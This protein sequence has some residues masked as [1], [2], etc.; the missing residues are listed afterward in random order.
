M[1]VARKGLMLAVAILAAGCAH[2][3]PVD[4]PVPGGRDFLD[5]DVFIITA[6]PD[7]CA[8]AQREALRSESSVRV[9]CGRRVEG[10]SIS[11]DRALGP[12]FRAGPE[13]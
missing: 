5:T 13:R 2:Q 11:A 9:F 7:A 3:R 10:P 8:E 12:G 4:E 1:R 6:T